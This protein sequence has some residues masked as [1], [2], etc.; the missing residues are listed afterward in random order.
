MVGKAFF[1]MGRGVISMWP[2]VDL[3]VCVV[4]ALL[5]SKI[6][7]KVEGVGEVHDPPFLIAVGE[8]R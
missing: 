7:R 6:S 2:S 5:G 4:G 1:A 8:E 3:P